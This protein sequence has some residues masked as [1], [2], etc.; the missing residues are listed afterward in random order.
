[1]GQNGLGFLTMVPIVDRL[2]IQ[3]LLDEN[4]DVRLMVKASGEYQTTL[5][6]VVRSPKAIVLECVPRDEYLAALYRAAMGKPLSTYEG[7]LSHA[8]SRGVEKVETSVV[9][10]RLQRRLAVEQMPMPPKLGV[11]SLVTAALSH[12]LVSDSGTTPHVHD[13]P[14]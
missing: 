9:L 13:T 1:M 10:S 12:M 6:H 8:V 5:A 14:I 7:I 11:P 3:R 2:R 4:D